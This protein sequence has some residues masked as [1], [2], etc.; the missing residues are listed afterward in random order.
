MAG[1]GWISIHRQIWNNWTWKDKPFSKGQAWIDILLLVN[2]NPDKVYF[3]DSIY[4]V[5]PG[6]RITSEL[7]LS[8]RW[9]WSRN[10]TRRFLNDLEREQQIDVKRDNRKTVI[11]VL[12]YTKYQKDNTTKGTT[13][14]T[15]E[16]QQMVQQK[17]INNNDTI[18]INN[19]NKKDIYISVPD[20]SLKSKQKKEKYGEF[21]EVCLTNDEFNKL[22]DKFGMHKTEDMVS[23]LDNYK[24]STGKRYKSDYATILNWNRKNENE[25]KNHSN[26]NTN[27]NPFAEMFK[28]VIGNEQ[29]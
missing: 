7:Q 2:H 8:E 21:E 19:E 26:G 24:A 9:G 18:M 25:P 28:E 20:E 17:D 6:Q 1:E 4:D 13:E 15:T 5:E 23:K 12:N 22:V 29:D 3:R 27:S 14:S 16:R 11:T 10:K